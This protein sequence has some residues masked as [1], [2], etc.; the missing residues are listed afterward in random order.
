MSWHK[1]VFTQNTSAFLFCPNGVKQACSSGFRGLFPG[2]MPSSLVLGRFHIRRV[3]PQ[4][5]IAPW[6]I[7]RSQIRVWAILHFYPEQSDTIA[8]LLS[9][10]LQT[11]L[12]VLGVDPLSGYTSHTLPN[13]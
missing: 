3:V 13:I 11:S 4:R 10:G 7:H 2:Y 6:A 9:V 8:V 12:A 1:K 5:Y